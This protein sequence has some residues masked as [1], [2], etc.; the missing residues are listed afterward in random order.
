[1]TQKRAIY[2]AAITAIVFF[3]GTAWSVDYGRIRF[4]EF[5]SDRQIFERYTEE[6]A[7]SISAEEWQSI[8]DAGREEMSAGWERD[9]LAERDRYIREGFDAGLV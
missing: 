6:A 7:E 1:M 2:T 5:S 9:A 4:R 8:L 3:A